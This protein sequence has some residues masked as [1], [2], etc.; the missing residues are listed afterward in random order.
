MMF[1]QPLNILRVQEELKKYQELCN[2]YNHSPAKK[3]FEDIV[4]FILLQ[5]GN[6]TGIYESNDFT[7]DYLYENF[8]QGL[9]EARLE[10]DGAAEFDT[11]AGAAIGAAKSVMKG[12]AVG[13]ALTGVYLAFLFKRGKLK[14]TLD[15]EKKIEMDKLNSFKKIIDLS[16]QV[17]KIKGEAPPK[18]TSLTQPSTTEEPAMPEKPDNPA[19]SEEK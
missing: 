6:G 11:A 4:N 14:S 16:V 3:E 15:N 7:V 12:L 9:N 8:L 5:S 19:S 13:A 2:Q 10:T 1:V 17:A 18:L